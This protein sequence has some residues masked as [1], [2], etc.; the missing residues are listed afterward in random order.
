MPPPR[1]PRSQNTQAKHR[2]CLLRASG[3]FTD[4]G[5][6]RT[7]VPLGPQYFPAISVQHVAAAEGGDPPP[8]VNNGWYAWL[9]KPLEKK[10]KLHYQPSWCYLLKRDLLL[11][12]PAWPPW[13]IRYSTCHRL[14]FGSVMF[15]PF[16]Q[17]KMLYEDEWRRWGSHLTHL[18]RAHW[19]AVAAAPW[20]AAA[21]CMEQTGSRHREHGELGRPLSCTVESLGLRSP[22]LGAAM[23]PSWKAHARGE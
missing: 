15:S 17:A 8:V 23:R 12:P 1:R 7:K 6:V 13:P 18:K 20:P 2:N 21:G 14:L 5:L 11:P 3:R 22:T 9:L 19:H 16:C 10:I 4:R